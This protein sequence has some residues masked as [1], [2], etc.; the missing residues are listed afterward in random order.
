M[1]MQNKGLVSIIIPTY[2]RADYLTRC[3]DNV[4]LQTYKDIEIIVVDDNGIGSEFQI[5]TEKLLLEYIQKGQIKYIKH[6]VNKN[7][8]AA[9]NTGLRESLGLYIKFLDD[10]DYLMPTCIEEQVAVL[11]QSDTEFGATYCGFETYSITDGKEIVNSYNY[12]LSG[13]L[14]EELYFDKVKFNTSA[15][16]FKRECILIL[17]GFD[18][19]YCRHQDLELMT[20]FFSKYRIIATSAG[21]LLRLDLTD[22]R[23]MPNPSIDFQV[24]EKFFRQFDSLFVEWNIKKEFSQHMWYTCALNA[25]KQRD[26]YCFFKSI[27]K[28]GGLHT[29]K[30]YQI[31]NITRTILRQNKMY[32]KI[33]DF[34][35]SM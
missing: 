15:L 34:C 10:D 24:K 19:T 5:E 33:R 32:R 31:L 11:S 27:K 17:D 28:M 14:H 26:F 16:L 25:L 21:C 29:F 12:T 7:G 8:S 22:R 23:N 2:K 3:I 6:D 9:R 1:N 35:K 30:K 4:L 20:R 13:D 18:E